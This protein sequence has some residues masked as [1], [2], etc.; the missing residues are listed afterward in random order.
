MNVM[1]VVE[2]LLMLVENDRLWPFTYYSNPT[3]L[4][5]HGAMISFRRY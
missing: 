1:V 3:V 2:L 4:T 5:N